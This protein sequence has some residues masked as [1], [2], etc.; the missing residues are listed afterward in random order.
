M[1]ATA[2]GPEDRSNLKDGQDRRQEYSDSCIFRTRY[3]AIIGLVYPESH[4]RKWMLAA[5]VA[6]ASVDAGPTYVI[7]TYAGGAPSPLGAAGESLTGFSSVTTDGAGNVYFASEHSVFKIERAGTLTRVAGNARAGYAGDGGPAT[8]AQLHMPYTIPAGLAVDASGN[9]YIGDQGNA[10]IRRVAP[11]GMITTFLGVTGSPAG[12]AFDR[13]GNLYVAINQLPPR[14]LKLTPAGTM[15]KIAGNGPSGFSGDGG[16]GTQAQ[17]DFPSGLAVAA[18]GSVYVSDMM[19]N[20]VRKIS[21]QGIITTVAGTGVSGFS[22]DGGPAVSAQL[23]QPHGLAIDASGNLYIATNSRVR[24]I[25]PQGIISTVVGDGTYRHDGDNGPATRA[26]L[27][28]ATWVAVNNDGELFVTEEHHL[29]KVTRDGVITTI[30]GE[31]AGGRAGTSLKPLNPIDVAVDGGGSVFVADKYMVRKVAPDGRM[32]IIAG[33]PAVDV[34][35]AVDNAGNLYVA[36]PSESCIRKISPAGAVLLEIGCP[37]DTNGPAVR[38]AGPHGI[39]LD[40]AGNLFVADSGANRIRRISTD[41]TVTVVAGSGRAGYSGDGSAALRAQLNF[42][43]DILVNAAGEIYIA[44]TLNHCIRKV[45]ADGIISTVAGSAISGFSGDGGSAVEAKLSRPHGLALDAAGDLYIADTAN[46]RVRKIWFKRP[47]PETFVSNL[48]RRI[49]STPPGATMTTA[50]GNGR[51]DYSGDG[52]P[53]VGASI[54]V[55]R[56]VAIDQAGNL[57]IGD[58]DNNRLRRVSP[59]G[60]IST[61]VSDIDGPRSLTIDRANNV[62]IADARNYSIRTLSA[63]GAQTRLPGGRPFGRGDYGMYEE[64]QEGGPAATAIIGSPNAIA[65]DG[66]GNVYIAD[67]ENNRV[68]KI[69]ANGIL[70][71]VVGFRDRGFSGDGEPAAHA[72]IN[73]PNGVAA[74]RAGNIYI[75]DGYNARIRKVSAA[76]IITTV[77]GIGV[78]GHSGDGGPATRAH[79]SIQAMQG[80]PPT[81]IAVDAQG[82]IYFAETYA[83]RVRRIAPNGIITTVAGRASETY[84]VGDTVIEK[85]GFAGDDGPATAAWLASPHGIAVLN[86]A[87]FIADTGNNRIRRVAGGII[88]TIAGN[89]GRGFTGD[90]GPGPN[91]EVYVP[92]GVAVDARGKVY[93]ATSGNKAIRVLEPR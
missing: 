64:P 4:M 6:W 26:S 62:Y 10:R 67:S 9:L 14:I 56:A 66:S 13:A 61:V 30:A 33:N 36:D 27:A 83:N 22:G 92:T 51:Y 20:R 50:A 24:R 12:I 28:G 81:G 84:N 43:T 34:A 35:I 90:G 87:L 77:A 48:Y 60:I 88:T 52:G 63:A 89:G 49:L 42:P 58:F 8:D 45:A 80:P 21:P 23:R 78:A 17:L 2:Q 55:P 39:A 25:T 38:L 68:R 59:D 7:S 19:N 93:I 82:N 72:Q 47:P 74:D 11:N 85:G 57:L 46:N 15:T 70:S 71:T 91:A 65:A 41:G 76:G 79:I 69:W 32:T 53:A 86:E 75:A 40:G 31:G 16:P 54:T 37:S 3:G 5:L 29:R 44:D 1:P 73:G 18:D